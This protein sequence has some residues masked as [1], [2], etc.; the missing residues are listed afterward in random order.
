[1]EMSKEELA[2][3]AG[4]FEVEFPNRLTGAARKRV[5]AAILEAQDGG[6]EDEDED[7]DEDGDE[8]YDEDAL[9]EMSLTDLKAV[10]TDEFELDI[11]KGKAAIVK[12]K[13]VAA[14][15]EAQEE[16][17]DED[18]DED[19]EDEDDDGYDDLTKTE[20]AKEVRSRGGKVK[21]GMTQAAMVKWLRENDAEDEDEDEDEDDEGGEDMD[22]D[23]MDL[24]EVKAALR[25]R[26]ISTRGSLKVLRQKLTKSLESDDDGDPF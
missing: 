16:A 18:E 15:L 20:L 10:A 23:S 13:L 12:K 3:T 19:G 25:E 9:K 8:E 22:P 4:E 5:V 24:D 21:Q 7:E 26:G 11:P 17:E 2:E 1:M 14:I 6:D